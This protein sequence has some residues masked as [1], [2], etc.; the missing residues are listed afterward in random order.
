MR[1]WNIGIEPALQDTH[2]NIQRD[3]VGVYLAA[4]VPLVLALLRKPRGA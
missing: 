2:G 1:P 3:F 4:A